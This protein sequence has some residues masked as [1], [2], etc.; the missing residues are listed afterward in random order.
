V[1]DDDAAAKPEWAVAAG[2]PIRVYEW[3]VPP[4]VL[5]GLAVIEIYA[6]T[7]AGSRGEP[8][9]SSIAVSLLVVAAMALWIFG[10]WAYRDLT[11]QAVERYA[12]TGVVSLLVAGALLSFGTVGVGWLPL[13]WSGRLLARKGLRPVRLVRTV[14]PGRLW[15]RTAVIAAIVGVICLLLLP[16]AIAL[17]FVPLIVLV[18]VGRIVAP[19]IFGFAFRLRPGASG[20][21]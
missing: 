21:F 11:P 1:E 15:L 9:F 20:M 8:V 7:S 5:V 12:V 14:M 4:L 18:M 6:E 2:A 3:L 17:G 16:L 19:F 13:V 10:Y